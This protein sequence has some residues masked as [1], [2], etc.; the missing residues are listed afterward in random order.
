MRPMVPLESVQFAENSR[1][2]FYLPLQGTRAE[3][4]SLPHMVPIPGSSSRSL[5]V[6]LGVLDAVV[7]SDGGAPCH[8]ATSKSASKYAGTAGCDPSRLPPPWSPPPQ[9]LACPRIAVTPRVV[10][11]RHNLARSELVPLAMFVAEFGGLASSSS[12]VGVLGLVMFSRNLQQGRNK[13]SLQHADLLQQ[14]NTKG[15]PPAAKRYCGPAATM[16]I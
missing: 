10:A 12:K 6:A 15:P 13:R 14:R 4:G 2:K 9:Q 16:H 1:I 5:E 8:S 7:I 11:P 3:G